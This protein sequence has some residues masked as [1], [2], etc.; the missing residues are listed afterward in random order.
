M[1][2]LDE[3]LSGEYSI[4]RE[5]L[6]SSLNRSLGLIFHLLDFTFGEMRLESVLD[7]GW[8]Y[9]E[10][11]SARGGGGGGGDAIGAVD[12]E[13]MLELIILARTQSAYK[14]HICA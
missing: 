11:E 5:I 6:C 14:D 10:G 13:L 2:S 9:S 12:G 1:K 4:E 7:L 3:E 8:E